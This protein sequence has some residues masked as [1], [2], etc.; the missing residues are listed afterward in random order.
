MTVVRVRF[1]SNILPQTSHLN[2]H[3]DP[4]RLCIGRG[5][6][7]ILEEE[8]TE[9][10]GAIFLFRYDGC[11]T[12]CHPLS[13][14]IALPFCHPAF[15]CPSDLCVVARRVVRNRRY[16]GERVFLLEQECSVSRTGPALILS[17]S[18]QSSTRQPSHTTVVL[19]TSQCSDMPT[20]NLYMSQPGQL[21]A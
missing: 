10:P 13:F 20:F 18:T 16:V 17:S 21:R 8:G 15:A 11:A 14:V 7:K 5:P 1:I 19:Q 6:L 4:A 9:R 12:P 2:R 3:P